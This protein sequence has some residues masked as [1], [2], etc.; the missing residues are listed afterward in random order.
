MNV[1]LNTQPAI[2]KCNEDLIALAV[3]NFLSNATKYGNENTDVILTV[4]NDKNSVKFSIYNES[5]PIPDE[6]LPHIW[7]ELYRVDKSRNSKDN[8]TG[9]GLAINRQIFEIHKFK[10]DCRNIKNGVEFSVE[11]K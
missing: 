8:S 5:D 4:T 3:D 2:I 1:Q 6:A 10:Y 9:M 11:I 7:E